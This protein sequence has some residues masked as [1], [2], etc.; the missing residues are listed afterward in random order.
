MSAHR[1]TKTD[2]MAWL[3]CPR[4]LWLRAHRPDT[5]RPLTAAEQMRIDAGISF[6]RGVT[7]LFPGGV[8][9]D[10]DRGIETGLAS[11]IR[12]HVLRHYRAKRT[13]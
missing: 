2:F 6:G 10:A 1:L 11:A 12:V 7:G 5:R 4:R 13:G 8:R 9:I 3:H